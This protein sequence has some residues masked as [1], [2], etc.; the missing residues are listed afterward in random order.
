MRTLAVDNHSKAHY[1]K[2]SKLGYGVAVGTD[3]L[4]KTDQRHANRDQKKL[5]PPAKAAGLRGLTYRALA[6]TIGRTGK[7][8]GLIKVSGPAKYAKTISIVVCYPI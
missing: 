1:H 3:E 4:P 5:I 6:E 8:Q 2:R 7:T